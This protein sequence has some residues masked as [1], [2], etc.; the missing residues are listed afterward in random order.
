MFSGMLE[1]TRA[2]KQQRARTILL[3]LVAGQHS[4]ALK[5]LS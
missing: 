5:G 2:T 4:Q 1:G 3:Q